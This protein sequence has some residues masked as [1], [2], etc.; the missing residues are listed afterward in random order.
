MPGVDFGNANGTGQAQLLQDY[1]TAH[2]HAIKA[3][4]VLIG[5]GDFEW[6]EL[7]KDCAEKWLLTET[8]RLVI[9][10]FEDLCQDDT[11]PQQMISWPNIQD[12]KWRIRAA[13]LN[14]REAMRRASYADA[15]YKI[16]LQTYSSPVPDGPG[17]R[18]PE[19]PHVRQIVGGCPIQD[20]DAT[21]VNHNA[22]TAMNLARHGG[23][24]GA[25][26][27]TAS[28]RDLLD[29]RDAFVGHRLCENTVGLLEERGVF[30]WTQPGAAD[31][32]EWVKQINQLNPND[33][34]FQEN[35]HP[36]Y[37]GYMALRNCFRQAYNNGSPHGGRCMPGGTAGS[38]PAASPTWTS[39]RSRGPRAARR[40]GGGPRPGIIVPVPA[41][42]DP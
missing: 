15:D 5:A 39:C 26:R 33:P 12:K 16:I 22:L 32:T 2:P 35:A 4:A 24:H 41:V 37:W 20:K 25:A 28:S 30:S 9:P 8:T 18:Y 3:V 21:W 29:A 36:N 14:V 6:T 23:A 34:S 7:A 40:L 11:G 1:A 19:F 38:T 10:W 17:F 27:A 31:R 13:V 42:T